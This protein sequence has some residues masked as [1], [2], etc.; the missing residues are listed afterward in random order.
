[1]GNFV[2]D[3][4]QKEVKRKKVL[5]IMEDYRDFVLRNQGN[6][7]DEDQ[8][9]AIMEKTVDEIIQILSNP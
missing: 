7:Y 6:L 2:I 9:D 5:K 1:M 4:L 8:K 3:P